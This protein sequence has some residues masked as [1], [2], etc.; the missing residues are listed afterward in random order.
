MRSIWRVSMTLA[1]FLLLSGCAPQLGYRD[2]E[3]E[4]Q[5]SD[6]G[7]CFPA[8]VLKITGYKL[9]EPLPST[10]VSYT[11]SIVEFDDHG[12]LAK[13]AQL[14]RIIELLKREAAQHDLSI[15]VYVHGWRHNA[16]RG[17]EDI[18]NFQNLL[19][20]L[21]LAEQQSQPKR[22]V[23]GIY[24]AWPGALFAGRGLVTDIVNTPSFWTRK[25]GANRVAEGT[26]R[27]LFAKVREV[28]QERNGDCGSAAKPCNTRL[29][30]IGHSFGALVAY[31]AVHQ[32][33]VTSAVRPDEMPVTGLG[34]LVILINPAFEGVRYA[35]IQRLVEGRKD[36]PAGQPPVLITFAS[37]GEKAN[38]FFFPLGRY[39][40]L[41]TGREW[42]SSRSQLNDLAYTIGFVDRFKTH[43]LSV[44]PAGTR[45]APEGPTCGDR[46]QPLP[47]WTRHYP[48][49]D[50]GQEAVLAHAQYN[51]SNPFW[52]V[53]TDAALVP[54]HSTIWGTDFLQVVY[55]IYSDFVRP[56]TTLCGVRKAGSPGA[57]TAG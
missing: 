27:E 42:P 41:L 21:D 26:I 36:Y 34:D 50:H 15:V 33:L 52:L 4:C 35:S 25:E 32:E 20:L 24:V 2:A 13:P 37:R 53:S 40:T 43:D 6:P 29:V 57:R 11:L 5:A 45:A 8:P 28:Q 17:D 49:P 16:S 22:K 12:V 23:V 14:D 46:G 51:P 7:T 47:G 30:T 44:V 56:E 3:G 10:P 55:D 19:G 18:R 38:R 54:N 31:S 1:L 9:P 48:L 39:V